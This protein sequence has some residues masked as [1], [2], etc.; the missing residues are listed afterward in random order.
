MQEITLKRIDQ[1]LTRRIKSRFGRFFE[2]DWP[3]PVVEIRY[4]LEDG[5]SV[6]PGVA[7]LNDMQRYW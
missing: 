2:D 7:I 4:L 3:G 5:C 1:V 6:K